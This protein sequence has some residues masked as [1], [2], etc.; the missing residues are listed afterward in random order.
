MKMAVFVSLDNK[1]NLKMIESWL[2]DNISEEE[3][4]IISKSPFAWSI[5][6]GIF[7]KFYGKFKRFVIETTG[8]YHIYEMMVLRGKMPF[9]LVILYDF[10]NNEFLNGE[11]SCYKT[12]Q[13][14]LVLLGKQKF[15]VRFIFTELNK[16]FF[17][18]GLVNELEKNDIEIEY[19]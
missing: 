5:I 14:I 19:A 2:E 1:S 3:V 13:T 10:Y 16:K 7:K 12:F 8:L 11:R 6:E 15:T 17:H 4:V 18:K 9:K